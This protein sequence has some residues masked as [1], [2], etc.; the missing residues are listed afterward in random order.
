MPSWTRKTIG[1]SQNSLAAAIVP[2]VLQVAITIGL[3][4]GLLI[5]LALFVPGVMLATDFLLWPAWLLMFGAI[6][7]CF[8]T[9]WT[10]AS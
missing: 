5:G 4:I 8:S 2:F 6:E 1:Q 10:L 7:A 9:M 3:V